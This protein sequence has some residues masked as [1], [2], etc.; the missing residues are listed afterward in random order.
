[1]LN[2]RRNTT[3]GSGGLLPHDQALAHLGGISK[4]TLWRLVQNGEVGKV[5]IG[6][7][8]LYSRDDLDDYIQR[9]L[10]YADADA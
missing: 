5:K 2:R 10:Q 8:A 9:Q 1:M 4:M 6:R 7:R 3:V